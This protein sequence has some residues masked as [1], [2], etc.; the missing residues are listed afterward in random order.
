VGSRSKARARAQASQNASQRSS[1]PHPGAGS[2]QPGGAAK[3]QQRGRVTGQQ[4]GVVTGR[5]GGGVTGQPGQPPRTVLALAAIQA[6][7]ATGILLAA[8]LAG[9]DTGAGKSYELA[10]G[11]AITAIG[12][13]TALALGLVARGLRAGRR[14]TRTPALLTQLFTGIIGIYL[15]QAPRYDWG[16][17]AALLA[18]AGLV[19]LFTPASVEVLTPGRADKSDP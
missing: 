2:R 17:P 7:E 12:V 15:L 4:A 13:C 8:I 11:I 16:V 3:G 14:W 6:I 1:A 9:L 10:S 19:L 5:P 18:V